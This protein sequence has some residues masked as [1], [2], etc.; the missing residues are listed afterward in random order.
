M[1]VSADFGWVMLLSVIALCWL[2]GLFGSYDAG[3][4]VVGVW[5]G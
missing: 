1:P 5:I 2:R 4:L 3:L